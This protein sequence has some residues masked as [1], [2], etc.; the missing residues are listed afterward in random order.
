M[1]DQNETCRYR[2]TVKRGDSFYMIAQRQGVRLR[3]L[4]EANPDIPPARLMVGDVLCIP[5]CGSANQPAQE[6]PQQ[7]LQLLQ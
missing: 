5:Y 3:D 4:L 2:Y 1:S 7:A 6:Q